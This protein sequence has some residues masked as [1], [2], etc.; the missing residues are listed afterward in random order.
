M[1]DFDYSDITTWYLGKADCDACGSECL[2]SAEF[3]PRWGDSGEWAFS[4]NVGC[5]GGDQVVAS[6]E[7]YQTRLREMF[8]VLRETSYGLWTS[9]QE[10]ELF[11]LIDNLQI[12]DN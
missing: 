8:V 7:D 10:S 1:S 9:E 4:Y 2:N 3:N 5:Y 6:D 11:E 12:S